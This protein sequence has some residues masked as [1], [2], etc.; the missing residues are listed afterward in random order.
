MP[1]RHQ[2][3]QTDQQRRDRTDHGNPSS[4][5]RRSLRGLAVGLGGD[6][7]QRLFIIPGHPLLGVL[8]G[9]LGGSLQRA[10]V[11]EGVSPGQLSGVDK[12]HEEVTTRAP[13]S[14]FTS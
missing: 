6:A 3:S 11:V 12:A 7:L 10:E 14:V 5:R 2:P 1:L 9:L 4:L 8:L 13:L